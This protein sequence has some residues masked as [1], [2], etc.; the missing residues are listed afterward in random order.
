LKLALEDEV[1]EKSGA[2]FSYK[3]QRLGQGKENAA[4]FLRDNPAVRAEIAAAVLEKRRPKTGDAEEAEALA[5]KEEAEAAAELAAVTG[6]PV[7][8]EPE[9]AKKKRGKAA[10]E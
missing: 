2:H 9:P 1:I 6:E 5:A 3:E 7:P 10:G 4:Q 8:V